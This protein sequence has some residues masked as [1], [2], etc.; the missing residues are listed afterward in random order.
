MGTRTTPRL[1][2]PPGQGWRWS[3]VPVPEGHLASL[4][5]GLCLERVRPW[6]LTFRGSRSLGWT[7]VAAGATVAAGAVRAAGQVDL[8]DPWTPVTSGPYRWV[9]HPMYAGWSVGYVGTA[10]VAGTAWPLGLAGPLAVWTVR[11]V[12]REERALEA[13]FGPL[14]G[15]GAARAQP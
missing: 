4:G 11:E 3:N 6:R 9:R 2:R 12:R 5:I 8:A 15:R 13:A 7:L 10:L 14:T 1:A